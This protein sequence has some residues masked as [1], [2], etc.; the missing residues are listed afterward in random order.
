MTNDPGFI[1]SYARER[2][3]FDKTATDRCETEETL[4]TPDD[5]LLSAANRQRLKHE[6]SL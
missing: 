1:R 3:S 6:A 4:R 5:S 2:R